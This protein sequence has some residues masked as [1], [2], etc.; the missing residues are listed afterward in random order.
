MASIPSERIAVGGAAVAQQEKLLF[1]II[2]II[3]ILIHQ[4]LTPTPLH[5][6]FSQH[7]Q[8]AG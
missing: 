4:Q 5:P 2:Y 1:F 6:S 7:P 8:Q 3:C